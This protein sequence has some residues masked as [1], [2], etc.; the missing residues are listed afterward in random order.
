MEKMHLLSRELCCWKPASRCSVLGSPGS[1]RQRVGKT[2]VL[3]SGATFWVRRR[4]SPE[5]WCTAASLGPPLGWKSI[6]YWMAVGSRHWRVRPEAVGHWQ[7]SPCANT[8]QQTPE[9]APVE[10][11]ECTVISRLAKVRKGNEKCLFFF[12]L[13]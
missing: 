11:N 12:F 9:W 2:A 10:D 7:W 4:D 13:K 8:S 1:L 5:Q 6:R 3:K